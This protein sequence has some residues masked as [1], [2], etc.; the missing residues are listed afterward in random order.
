MSTEPSH[1]PGLRVDARQNRDRIVD[2]ARVLFAERGLDVPMTA[3]A[4]RAEVGVA[5]LYRR[6]PTKESLI[7]EAF[8]DQFANCTA[9]I[10][11]ALADPDPWRGFCS[12][13]EKVFAIQAGD[14]GFSAAFLAAL[15]A[16]VDI[17]QE[18]DRALR[19]FA[20]LADR[21]KEAGALR[22][23]FALADLPLLLMANNGVTTPAASRRLLGYLLNSLR[24]EHAEPL[25]PPAPL[26]LRDLC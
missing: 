22:A 5:T 9:I 12:V 25:P 6:F 2:V 7:T 23:D 17:D 10:Y 19:S 16:A 14:R 13:F 24:A 18:L 4:R 1:L 15:P 3:I 26:S 20:T 11:D 21:A 8:A